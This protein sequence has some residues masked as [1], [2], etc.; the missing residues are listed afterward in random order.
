MSI[1]FHFDYTV[2]GL[3][4][5]YVVWRKLGT[6]NVLRASNGTLIADTTANRA[7]AAHSTS[8]STVAK[9]YVGTLHDDTPDGDYVGT[10]YRQ[11]GGG[12]VAAD[13]ELIGFTD[14]IAVRGGA[15]SAPGEVADETVEL[16][17]T[18]ATASASA[19]AGSITISFR[20]YSDGTLANVT[21]AVLEDATDTFGVKR[22]D[23]D[24]VVVAA[25]TALSSQ[26]T[27]TYAH[28][29]AEPTVGLTFTAVVKFV[30][31]SVTKYRELSIVGSRTSGF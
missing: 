17:A 8:D 21:S 19:R 9:R 15:G 18:L 1:P 26:G 16:E 12:P 3:T 11:A 20:H 7:N 5:I 22:D 27:G 10:A 2:D 23:T 28:S 14:V 13:D 29:F 31:R 24:A 25:G 30:Y 6:S 4:D